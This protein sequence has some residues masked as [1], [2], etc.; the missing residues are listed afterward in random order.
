[1]IANFFIILLRSI[2]VEGVKDC[3]DYNEWLYNIRVGY[4]YWRYGLLIWLGYICSRRGRKALPRLF[5]V[6]GGIFLAYK[7]VL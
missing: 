5:H 6:T 1:M 7:Y 2:A 4:P 3:L